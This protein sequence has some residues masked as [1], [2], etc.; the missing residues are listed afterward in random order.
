[1]SFHHTTFGPGFAAT[2]FS[3]GRVTTHTSYGGWYSPGRTYT[4]T[5]V[6]PFGTSTYT[7]STLG[8]PLGYS[9]T[10]TFSPGYSRV[11][12][13]DGLFGSTVTESHY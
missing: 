11:T 3:P 4:S 5:R 8:G 13:T 2:S 6:G 9:R 7:S 12:R 10:T 1:M